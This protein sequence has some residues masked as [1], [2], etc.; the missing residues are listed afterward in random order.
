VDEH[1]YA[2]ID[3]VKIPLNLFPATLLA[4]PKGI[5][6]GLGSIAYFCWINDD[7]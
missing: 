5:H 7:V 3:K 1:L 2:L 6:Q 4:S